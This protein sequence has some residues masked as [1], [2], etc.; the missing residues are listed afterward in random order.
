MSAG[1][2]GARMLRALFHDEAHRRD[3]KRKLQDKSSLREAFMIISDLISSGEF[4]RALRK[5]EAIAI[6][7]GA[8]RFMFGRIDQA[9]KNISNPRKY[10]R[11]TEKFI[12]AEAARSFDF[13]L[14]HLRQTY[15]YHFVQIRLELQKEKKI[16]C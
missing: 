8:Y 6:I 4:P 14:R 16:A 10:C 12:F 9:S 11:C 5:Q 2:R 7:C 13:A 1:E 3:L 15:G